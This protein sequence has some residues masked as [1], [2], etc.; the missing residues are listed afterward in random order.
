VKLIAAV[1]AFRFSSVP[2]RVALASGMS[3]AQVGEFSFVLA[4]AGT[5]SGLLGEIGGQA[6]FAGAVFSL[7]LTPLLVAKAPEWALAV[8][9]RRGITAAA[10]APA[11]QPDA[12]EKPLSDH[13][14]IAGFGLN[15]QNLARVL[16]AVRL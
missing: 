15:G 2:W 9:R 3:L 6:F 4:A 16:R 5:P 12:A 11:G 14:V 10:S 8:E 13:V 7:M 1:I